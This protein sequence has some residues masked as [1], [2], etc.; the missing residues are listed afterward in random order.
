MPKFYR[1]NRKRIDPR[2]F[3]DETTNRDDLQSQIAAYQKKLDSEETE[4]KANIQADIDA[5]GVKDEEEL[6]K[7][8]T[9]QLENLLRDIQGNP[10]FFSGPG[11]D[12]RRRAAGERVR[13]ALSKRPDYV[14]PYEPQEG[15]L[16]GE[17]WMGGRGLD[18]REKSW[19]QKQAA[20]DQLAGRGRPRHPQ[21]PSTRQY[22]KDEEDAIRKSILGSMA[23]N[24]PHTPG[25]GFS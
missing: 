12:E 10:F 1:Q 17:A 11:S 15:D 24:P 2:Y 20:A 25:S 13:I 16:D 6:A 4:K 3:L 7:L 5:D 23:K 19:A 21:R 18:V 9:E 14:N 22:T 8:S